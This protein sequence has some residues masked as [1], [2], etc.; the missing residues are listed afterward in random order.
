MT[1]ANHLLA[2]ALVAV[3]VKN[4]A[5][6]L[7][8]FGYEGKGYGEAFKHRLIWIMEAFGLAGIIALLLIL[9]GHG[10]LVYVAAVVAV[11]PDFRWPYRY[12]WFGRKG[13]KPPKADPITRFHQKAQWCEHPWGILIELPWFIALFCLLRV[14]L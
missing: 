10:C 5:L 1:T 13:L 3:S 9:R 11:S 12:F 7:P 14:I 4:P 2:G 8:H 6:A